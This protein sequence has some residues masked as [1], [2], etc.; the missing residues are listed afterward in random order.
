MCQRCTYEVASIN[1][2]GFLRH[3]QRVG[4]LSSLGPLFVFISIFRT[5]YTDILQLYKGPPLEA[6]L[7]GFLLQPNF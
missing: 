2:P 6:I 5:I 4:P 3:F 7:G 1:G